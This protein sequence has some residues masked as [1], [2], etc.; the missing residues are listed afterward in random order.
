[1]DSLPRITIVTPSYNQGKYI[2]QTILSVLGQNYPHLEYIVMDGGSTDES[3]DII[4]RYADRLA[5]WESHKDNG[6]ADAIFRG[7]EMSTGE[8]LAFLNSDDIL[9]PNSLETVGRYFVAHPREDWVVGSCLFIDHNARYLYNYFGSPKFNLGLRVSFNSLLYWGC[10][11]YQPASFWRRSAFFEIEGFDRSLK[12][13]FD[14]DLFLRLARRGP[15]GHITAFLASFRVHPTSKTATLSGVCLAENE[16]LWRKYGRYQ[17]SKVYQK[18][19]HFWY[20]KRSQVR[21]WII[22]FKLSLGRIRVPM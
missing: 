9:M 15:S 14:Y 8:V 10:G 3:V 16:E 17:K 1:M 19:L 2:E 21:S 22:Q 18:C 12:F 6:Q 20:A 11:F 5:H 13:C 7:F 4:R